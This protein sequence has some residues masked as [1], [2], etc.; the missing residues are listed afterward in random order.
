MYPS[1]R[2]LFFCQVFW[3]ASIF[4]HET[5]QICDR[6]LPKR[7]MRCGCVFGNLEVH[8]KLSNTRGKEWQA[9]KRPTLENCG[10]FW[11]CCIKITIVNRSM[12]PFQ[13]PQCRVQTLCPWFKSSAL[14]DVGS[15]RCPTVDMRLSWVLP[16]ALAIYPSNGQ[17]LICGFSFPIKIS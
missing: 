8:L 9:L 1:Q 4:H 17:V 2:K 16:K 13:Q 6:L 12:P 10:S 11:L 14:G 15:E 3:E 5:W 7:P